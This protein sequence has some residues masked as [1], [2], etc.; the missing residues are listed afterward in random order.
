MN[1]DELK[2]RRGAIVKDMRS[3]LDAATQD[4]RD[5]TADEQEKYEKMEADVDNLGNQIDRAE[6]L[7][8]FED[9]LKNQRDSN[10]AADIEEKG[11]P[12]ASSKYKDAFFNGYARLGNN[13]MQPQ[14]FNAL[15]I[16]TDSEG[17]YIVPEEFETQLVRLLDLGNPIRSAANVIRTSS[18]RNIPVETDDGNFGWIAEEGAYGTDDPAFG[19]VVLSSYKE[20][21]MVKVSE[22][23]LQDSFFDMQS[24]MLD[25]ASRRYNN[26]EDAA[27]GNGNGTGKPTGLFATS[28]VAGVTVT[29][30]TGAVSATPAITGNDLIDTF[31]GLKR[32]YRQQSTWVTSDTLAKMIRK[33]KDS[34]G[35]YIWQPGLTDDQPDR[36]LGR[37]V[38]ITEGAPTIAVSTKSLILADLSQYR[39]V[40]RVGMTMKRLNELYAANGQI[41]FQFMKRIDAKF[42]DPKA[43]TF[44]AHG[45][46]S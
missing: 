46:A 40:E 13:G 7:I 25:L 38:I 28:T 24:Y 17:G 39:I 36:I 5:L 37:P 18:D 44:F 1:I 30:T 8:T 33:L 2:Q 43:I 16:G 9:E 42:V 10:Y 21:G 14:H 15:Q 31:H 26:L 11:K 23:L 3:L 35:Q 32:S 27:F 4:K 6:K 22:E 12:R 20:G 19:R 34:D 29:G 45:A 41:G